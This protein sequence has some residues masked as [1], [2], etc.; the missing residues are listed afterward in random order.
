MGALLGN[1]QLAFQACGCNSRCFHCSV[2]DG[3]A[4]TPVMPFAEIEQCI[5]ATEGTNDRAP[6]L[7]NHLNVIWYS[8]PA[9]H[10]ALLELLQLCVSRGCF[11]GVLATNGERLATEP[12]FVPGVKR[13]GL[14]AV[15]LSF[16]GWQEE[17]DRLEGRRGAWDQKLIVVS[18]AARADLR[19][20][21]Q[22]FFRKGHASCVERIINAVDRAAGASGVRH[23][24]SVWM[25]QGRGA[26]LHRW[27]PTEADFNSLPGRIRDL[28]RLS[29]FRPETEWVHLAQNGRMDALLASFLERKRE[30][31][32]PDRVLIFDRHNVGNAQAVLDN[33]Y[34]ETQS[35]PRASTLERL[36]RAPLAQ[37]AQQVGEPDSTTMYSAIS[38]RQEWQRRAACQA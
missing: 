22:V 26:H 18:R 11:S 25:P 24:V 30:Q 6:A 19:V 27:V 28:P 4:H 8:E 29:E 9:D 1:L 12:D 15:Q 5:E 20:H 10:P 23:S 31:G 35:V 16:Y 17:H 21:T 36:A 37:W 38:M 14:E 7:C 3:A 32:A 2:G 34:A 13:A 33:L